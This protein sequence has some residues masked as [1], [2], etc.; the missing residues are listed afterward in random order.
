MV[1]RKTLILKPELG[2]AH[3]GR[4]VPDASIQKTGATHGK[5]CAAPGGVLG[6]NPLELEAQAELHPSRQMRSARM[7]EA[8][9][10]AACVCRRR[11]DWG[12]VHAVSHAVILRVIEQVEILPAEIES[13]SLAEGESLKKAKI[14]IDAAW[15]GQRVASN[16][17]KCQPDWRGERCGIVKQRPPDTRNVRLN[18]SVWIAH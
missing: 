3:V 8:R 2:P 11:T 12:A 7:Q 13:V 6:V 14:E 1:V 5:K 4:K 9:T 16:V 17:A 15:I 18:R 10:G